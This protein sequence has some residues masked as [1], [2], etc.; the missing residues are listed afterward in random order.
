MHP[1]MTMWIFSL[2]MARAWQGTL[3]N[4]HIPRIEPTD[5][6]QSNVP[7]VRA[8]R[9]LQPTVTEHPLPDLIL[10]R[11]RDVHWI[12]SEPALGI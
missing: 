4:V 12:E 8:S 10:D 1:W 3:I 5:V 9:Y 11:L 6:E 2:S 7:A